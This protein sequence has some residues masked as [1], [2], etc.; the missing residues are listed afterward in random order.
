MEQQFVI[1]DS[2]DYFGHMVPWHEHVPSITPD[3]GQFDPE[4]LLDVDEETMSD[5]STPPVSR[6][7]THITQ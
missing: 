6:S 7:I 3:M 2:P 1:P 4:D 5:D